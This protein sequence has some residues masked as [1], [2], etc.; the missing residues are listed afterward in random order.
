MYKI[1]LC[2]CM[3]FK[4]SPH[5]RGKR[6]YHTI[7]ETE[8]IRN[9]FQNLVRSSKIPIVAI[10]VITILLVHPV[11]MHFPQLDVVLVLDKRVSLLPS[12]C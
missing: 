6:K 2:V 7:E 4:G 11:L 8:V 12:Q 9:A 10:L 5:P 1:S 3:P